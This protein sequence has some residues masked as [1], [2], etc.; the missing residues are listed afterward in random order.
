M[1]VTTK[2]DFF[3]LCLSSASDVKFTV[4]ANE[5]Q[6]LTTHSERNFLRILLEQ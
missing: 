1:H 4:D 5:F 3:M 2:I 6:T